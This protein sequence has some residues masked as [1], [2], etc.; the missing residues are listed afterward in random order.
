MFYLA[1]RPG[2]Q[3]CIFSIA[4][5]FE[6]LVG[7]SRIRISILYWYFLLLLLLLFTPEQASVGTSVV[8]IFFTFI[9]NL[10]KFNTQLRAAC[11]VHD[12]SENTVQCVITHFMCLSI[13]TQPD[14]T[15]F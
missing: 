4:F 1:D 14:Q 5:G 9:H 6:T 10:K 2:L 3:V 8:V 11:E 13:K 12:Q 7:L 15:F